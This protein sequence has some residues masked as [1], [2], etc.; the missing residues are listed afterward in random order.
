M[1]V[2][3]KLYQVKYPMFGP[4]NGPK[5]SNLALGGRLKYNKLVQKKK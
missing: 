5:G 1:N 4:G 3:I 2:N